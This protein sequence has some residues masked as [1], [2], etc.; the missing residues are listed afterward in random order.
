MARLKESQLIINQDGSIYHLKLH[1]ENI[2]DDIILVGDP[3]RVDTVSGFFEKIIFRDHNREFHTV[4]GSLKG[5]KITVISTGIGPDNIDIV[6]NELDAL[7]NIDLRTRTIKKDLRKLNLYRLG[8][9][10]AIQP[11]IEIDTFVIAEYGMGIDGLAN[12]YDL[13]Q[14]LFVNTMETAFAEHTKWPGKLPY[15]YVLRCS[16][17]LLSKLTS[18]FL[19]G[20]TLTTPGFY[21]PQGRE[22]RLNLQYPQLPELIRSFSHSGEKIMNYEMETSALYA[23]GKALGH[24]VITICAI[25]A[26]RYRE[27]YSKNATK[28]INDLIKKVLDHI[29][30]NP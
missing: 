28:T 11:Y 24:N 29:V 1:P 14:E 27:E 8:T 5:K 6:L 12:F 19:K 18:G 30:D 25:L 21:A 9:S 4:T 2:A 23:L 20:I 15:P 3:G 26:N 16:D 7:V 10:G 17:E 22:L 13:K